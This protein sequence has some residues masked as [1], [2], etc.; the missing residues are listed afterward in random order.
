MA[1]FARS[2]KIDKIIVRNP[3]DTKDQDLTPQ[4]GPMAFYEDMI[5][6]SFHAEVMI[7]DTFGWLESF[8]I[9]SGSKVY[10]RIEHPTSNIDFEKEPLYI[11]NIKSAGQTDKKEFFVM[12][13]E[14]KAAFNNHLTRLY[15]KYNAPTNEV[16]EDIL[17]N[18]LEVPDNRVLELEEPSNKIEFLGVYKRPLQTCVGLAVK[19]IPSNHSKKEVTKGGSGMF[20]WET[21]KGFRFQSP[22]QIFAKAFENKDDV[23]KYEKV[24]TF[25]ALDP[26]NNF[27]L[28]SDP[29]WQNNHN[30]FEK[31]SIGQYTSH[32]GLF[33]SS[34]REHVVIE[35]DSLAKH[36][37]NADK[38]GDIL[39]N[40]EY[41]QPKEFSSVPSRHML[42]VKDERLFDNSDEQ[43]D[44]SKTSMEHVEYEARRQSRYSA[45]FSQSLEV[46]VPLNL[47]LHAGAVVNLKFPRINIDKPSG[48]DN[49][50]ASGFYMIK[51]LSHKFG[52]EGDFTGMH[53]VRDAYTK[54][55]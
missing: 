5:D 22:D 1:S 43:D 45:L 53:L 26:D 11:S 7:F 9:R 40:S 34:S 19:S 41:F 48:G 36:D 54:L 46:T 4:V 32:F 55:S 12:Q 31:L 3:E 30:L 6:A 47:S 38:D 2:A 18:D 27:H 16:V 44:S 42:L 23:I 13:L 33:D 51:T 14:S 37:Y 24:A 21:L 28:T 29:I 10:L 8:P 49:S 39:S 17:V 50:P 35:R 25:N 52:S 20:F 15:K